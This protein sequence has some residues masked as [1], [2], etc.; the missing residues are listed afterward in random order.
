MSPSV[1]KFDIKVMCLSTISDAIQSL[2]NAKLQ[3]IEVLKQLKEKRRDYNKKVAEIHAS[4]GNAMAE[5][6]LKVIIN[7]E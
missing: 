7:A 2:K 6:V 3:V 5:Q 4:A 1:T